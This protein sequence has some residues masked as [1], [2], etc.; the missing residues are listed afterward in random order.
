MKFNS[1]Q[2]EKFIDDYVTVDLTIQADA[3][4][5]DIT[6]VITSALASINATLPVRESSPVLEGI[7]VTRKAEI[8]IQNTNTGIYADTNG[9]RIV[10]NLTVVSPTEITLSFVRETT[11]DAYTIKAPA[12][13]SVRVPYRFLFY[14]WSDRVD[15]M[16]LPVTSTVRPVYFDG[17][18]FVNARADDRATLATFVDINGLRI[19]GGRVIWP[20]HGLFRGD[21][22]YLSTTVAGGIVRG[23]P[24]SGFVQPILRVE[25]EN[26]VEIMVEQ[27]AEAYPDRIY[28]TILVGNV[29]AISAGTVFSTTGNII[30]ATQGGTVPG[31]G[32]VLVDHDPISTSAPAFVGIESVGG[33]SLANLRNDVRVY[34]PVFSRQST[35][36]TTI[37]LE[38]SAALAGNIRIH[39]Y[40][41]DEWT[42]DAFFYSK[43]IIPIDVKSHLNFEA[44]EH[45]TGETWTDGRS[46]YR[47][48]ISG[49]LPSTFGSTTLASIPR[50][51]S[52]ID[53][54]GSVTSGTMVVPLPTNLATFTTSAAGDVI[55]IH[56]SS[57][58]GAPF[59]IIVEYTK[60]EG[61]AQTGWT[62]A[63]DALTLTN[64]TSVSE[65]LVTT[66]G[67][68]PHVL[69]IVGGALPEGLVLSSFTTT[70]ANLT[71]TPT[72]PAGS[73]Y[74]F[75]IR[76]TDTNGD[77][78][79]FFF[80]GEIG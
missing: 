46:I 28:G 49:T 73:L 8:V 76:S 78:A 23:R 38:E 48:V 5:F 50:F 27:A 7:D 53:L 1:K 11:N 21:T 66:G 65:T 71:G 35:T 9:E 13:L 63:P 58:D 70:G 43:E 31:G 15:V 68:A 59:S 72:D 34:V 19:D 74:S 26:I 17:T 20:N 36:R 32:F 52:L 37:F 69:S 29:G 10:G 60:L 41:G 42:E 67:T 64:G 62:I 61:T 4:S 12:R 2:I 24:L 80:S 54:R 18:N 39:F 40:M 22:Y 25:D 45:A 14:K 47:L 56:D 75:T 16:S 77:F 44:F 57:L 6:S 30:S 51:G 3:S 33:N 79:D 55:Q